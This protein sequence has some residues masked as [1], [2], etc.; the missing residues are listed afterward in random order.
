MIVEV[1]C[2]FVELQIWED[3]TALLLV[4]ENSQA[5]IMEASAAKPVRHLSGCAV[6][7]L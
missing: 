4:M 5:T 2:S 6:D 7:G 1:S 3:P